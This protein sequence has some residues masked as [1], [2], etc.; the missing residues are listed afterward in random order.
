MKFAP[1]ITSLYDVRAL[2]KMYTSINVLLLDF[3][4]LLQQLFD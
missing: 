2:S 4:Y 1:K 3:A